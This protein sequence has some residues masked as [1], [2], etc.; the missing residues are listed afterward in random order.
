MQIGLKTE[1]GDCPTSNMNAMENYL[2]SQTLTDK[3]IKRVWQG[4]GV[5][6]L[7]NYFVLLFSIEYTKKKKVMGDFNSILIQG[8]ISC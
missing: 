6:K 4:I 5:S 1:A 3:K 2:L 7:V 8:N